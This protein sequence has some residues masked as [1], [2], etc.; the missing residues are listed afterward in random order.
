MLKDLIKLMEDGKISSKQA[1]EV[2]F[3]V[4]EES[5]DP[6]TIIESLGIKQTSDDGAIREI[7]KGILD[8]NAK[9]IEEYKNG[10]SNVL[11]FF[12]GQ[13]MKA[14]RGQAN[15]KMAT[16]IIKEEVDKR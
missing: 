2:F 14:T 3:K 11:D 8:N 13:V 7:V 16:S 4:V 6:L 10:R 5:K 9:L 15:P 12:M 1:K